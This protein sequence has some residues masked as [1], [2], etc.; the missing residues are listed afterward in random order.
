MI[1]VNLKPDEATRNDL[2][3]FVKGLLREAVPAA[4]IEKFAEDGWLETRLKAALDRCSI[5][6]I[7]IGWLSNS[8]AWEKGPLRSAINELVLA[9]H[10]VW[11]AGVMKELESQVNGTLRQVQVGVNKI[12]E[13]AAR[14]FKAIGEDKIR[15]IVAEELRRRLA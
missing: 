1:R 7:V 3:V 6:E 4:L 15:A 13:Q 12:L 10:S 5:E 14:D 8:P 9:Q 2:M 11:R